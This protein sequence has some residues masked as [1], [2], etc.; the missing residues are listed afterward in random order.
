MLRCVRR[1][2]TSSLAL[3]SKA[4]LSTAEV[5]SSCPWQRIVYHVAAAKGVPVVPVRKGRATWPPR[6]V[7]ATGES[8]DGN[9]FPAL[10]TRSTS[11]S[12][13]STRT[14]TTA[15]SSDAPSSP[16]DE[17]DSISAAS[18]QAPQSAIRA[19]F[20]LLRHV[21]EEHM[22]MP[23]R[24]GGLRGACRRLPNTLQQR[25]VA[26]QSYAHGSSGKR[27]AAHGKHVCGWQAFGMSCPGG[28]HTYGGAAQQAAGKLAGI[29]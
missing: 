15:I 23:G 7:C 25:S 18:W 21:E 9:V 14:T 27:S 10:S 13:D 24:A 20:L 17:I 12:W 3:L 2:I 4:Q 19:L 11:S 6:P 1:H 16:A 26:G 5:T 28:M 8:V 29:C 22:P